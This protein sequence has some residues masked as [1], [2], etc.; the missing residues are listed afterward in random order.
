MVLI[1]LPLRIQSG[2]IFTEKIVVAKF[3]AKVHLAWE[4]R[5]TEDLL[6]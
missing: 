2:M 5:V 4:I 3:S 1:L 6:N